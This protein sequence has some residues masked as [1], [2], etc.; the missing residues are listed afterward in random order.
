M[1]SVVFHSSIT[2]KKKEIGDMGKTKKNISISVR[3]SFLLGSAQTHFYGPNSKPN[4]LKS[5]YL[6][7]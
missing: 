2:K 6:L 7:G 3:G 4:C 1:M 5:G